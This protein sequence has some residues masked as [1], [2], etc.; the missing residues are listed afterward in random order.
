MPAGMLESRA[1]EVATAL[2]SVEQ[3]SNERDE[4]SRCVV[5]SAGW[6]PAQ[7]AAVCAFHSL[8]RWFD[9]AAHALLASLV[10]RLQQL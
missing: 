6:A 5:A 1:Q 2:T 7:G 9:L 10:D 4:Q 8:A 3:R